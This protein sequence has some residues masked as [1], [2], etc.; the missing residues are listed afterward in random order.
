MGHGIFRAGPV[1]HAVSGEGLAGLMQV[2]LDYPPRPRR[3]PAPNAP[4]PPAGRT[5]L[6]RAHQDRA[7]V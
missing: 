5:G 6:R 1:S 4:V 7:G 3:T 2:R